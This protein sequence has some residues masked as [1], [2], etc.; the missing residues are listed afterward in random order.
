MCGNALDL[1]DR[2]VRFVKPEPV[3]DAAEIAA[4]DVWMTGRMRTHPS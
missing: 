4:S 1:H 2:R 3:L